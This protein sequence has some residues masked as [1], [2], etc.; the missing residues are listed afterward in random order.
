M[1]ISCSIMASQLREAH[2]EALYEKLVSMP[3]E[4]VAAVYDNGK[5]EWET[6]RRALIRH[7]GCD[8]HL[9]I[10]DD[11]IIGDNFYANLEN[12]LKALPEEGLLSLYLGKVRPYSAT[13]TA[14][15]NRA[16]SQNA[17]FIS[18]TTLLW[19]VGIAIPTKDIQPM[20]KHVEKYPNKL[21]DV[22]IGQYYYDNKRPVF[23]TTT[24]LVDHDHTLPSLTGH[25][26]KTQPRVAHRYSDEILEFNQLVV[27]M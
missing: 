24:S 8:Y 3:F 7:F 16:S 17:S 5:G 19:G 23:Y 27:Q 4:N 12:A 22:R 26:K 20:L 9:V 21:Y 14:A 6:G 1:T 25:D 10:Q 18:H 15:F 13:V 11:A 2:A